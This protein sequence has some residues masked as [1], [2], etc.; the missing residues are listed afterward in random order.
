MKRV[1]I[2]I[3]ALSLLTGL[4]ALP[5][6]VT[7]ADT[8]GEP[9]YDKL[10]QSGPT[11]TPND[12][13]WLGFAAARDALSQKLNTRITL[14]QRYLWEQTEFTYGITENCVDELPEGVE[15]PA[16]YFGWIYNIKLLNGRTYQINVSFDLL[17]V[18]I[19]DEVYVD[20][21][22]GTTTSSGGGGVVGNVVPG[23]FEIGAQV[24]NNIGSKEATYLQ[25]GKFKWVKIQAHEGDNWCGLI[26]AAHGVGY[27]VLLS[28]IGDKNSV[29]NASYQDG[30]GTWAASQAACGADAI[31]VWNEANI[32]R[33]W[34]TGQISGAN[35]VELIKRVY[36]KVKAANGATIVISAA[37]AP[38]GFAGA[39][40]IS[41]PVVNDDVWYQQ[42]ADA[43][44]AQYVDCI[45]VHYNEGVVSP[46][47]TSGDPR[48]NYPTRYFQTNLGRAL[49]P[50]PGMK[51]CFTE[52][53]YLSPEGYGP[54][55][56]GFAW[57]ANT[58]VAEQAQWLGEAAVLASQLGN[59]RLMIVFNLNFTLYGADPQAGYAIVRADGT[60]PACVTL[61]SV[62]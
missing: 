10:A 28:S 50:F 35:Y 1:L 52:I 40:G 7:N 53:G 54:L 25:Q 41:D 24:P 6:A 29:T 30:F 16:V 31:E 37:P 8:I 36:P 55:P 9:N 27:K 22:T 62:Q 33:E 58:S 59:V 2:F 42:V 38:T 14:V 15:A 60:C 18:F 61:A 20:L 17:D 48:D 49:S 23:S 12:P 44:G 56:G 5:L 43:G 39:A 46:K 3:F 21:G 19:C 47:V 11:A 45:G 34:P 26:S 4:V 32:D 57:G 13:N 51:A